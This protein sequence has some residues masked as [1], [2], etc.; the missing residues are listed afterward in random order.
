M[1][2]LKRFLPLLIIGG[3]VLIAGVLVATK[4]KAKPVLAEEKA[5]LVSAAAVQRQ[6]L[7]PMLTLF[8][9]VESLWSS[10]LT[11][12]VAADVAEVAV[13][14]GDGVEQGQLLLRLDDRDARLQMLQREADLQEA[15][16]KIDAENTRHATNL[17]LLPRERRLLNLTRAEVKRLQ[18]L[19]AKKVGAQSALDTARQAA[20]RQAITL[21]AREQSI[22]QHAAN[23]AELE[24]RRMRADALLEQ[25][26]LEVTRCEVRAP[27]NARVSRLLVSPG[28]RVRVGD[29]LVEVYDTDALVVRAQM[30]NR[31]LPTVRE[32]MQRGERLQVQGSIDG[33][34]VTAVLRSLAGEVAR[35]SGGVE[36]LFEIDGDA[37]V[38]RQG[39]FVRL[40][41]KLPAVDALVALPHEAVYGTEFV[42]RIDEQNRIRP[43]RIQRVGETRLESG[44]SRVLVRSTELQEGMR[45]ITTQLPNALDGLLVRVAES[46]AS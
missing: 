36:G 13:I 11:A 10:Q 4:P 25:A 14:E 44:E 1:T 28:K 9:K 43:L 5:W 24:A 22:A 31:Y 29:A 41:L 20:E 8:G 40:D 34:P 33:Q 46:D 30:P 15:Q 38:L 26:M 35:G 21:A 6:S 19:V 32:A 16:A 12:G 18:D 2:H 39:R 27:F 37:G 17:E 45:V 23:L 7:S 3:A 42:Y